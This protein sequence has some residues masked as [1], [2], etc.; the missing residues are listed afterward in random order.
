YVDVTS[1][2][3]SHAA[4]VIPFQP[5]AGA[6][7]GDEGGDTELT[8]TTTARL[9]RHW[10]ARFAG[11][12]IDLALMGVDLKVEPPPAKAKKTKKGKPSAAA[13]AAPAIDAPVP[14]YTLSTQTK[15]KP[16]ALINPVIFTI[17]QPLADVAKWALS[18]RRASD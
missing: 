13:P 8:L 1:S 10:Q 3:G 14:H 5:R 11:S 12:P 4:F 2:D 17:N 6:A 16:T 18:V 15:K 9:A 7:Q